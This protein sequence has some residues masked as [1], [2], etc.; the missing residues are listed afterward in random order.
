MSRSRSHY[1]SLTAE[2]HWQIPK[3]DL[4]IPIAEMKANTLWFV[5]QRERPVQHL[6]FC[7]IRLEESNCEQSA[8]GLN[9]I[10][11]IDYPSLLHDN[12]TTLHYPNLPG[13]FALLA[14]LEVKATTNH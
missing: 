8:M 7:V 4:M 10:K 14:V 3:T 1:P 9:S 5:L 12:N 2:S 11:F 6:L 13:L